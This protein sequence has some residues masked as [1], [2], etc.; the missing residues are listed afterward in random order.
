MRTEV[1]MFATIGYILPEYWRCKGD[2][3]PSHVWA[4]SP[5][6]PYQQPF[7]CCQVPWIPL[8]VPGHQVCRHAQRPRSHLQ[9]HGGVQA[10]AFRGPSTLTLAQALRCLLIFW[11]CEVVGCR[12]LASRGLLGVSWFQI[13]C[14]FCGLDEAEKSPHP[15][16]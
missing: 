6:S 7:A 5:S 1:S 8:Q 9:G 3:S 13:P 16:Q 12:G 11:G 4:M 14:L 10:R 15:Q 2:G